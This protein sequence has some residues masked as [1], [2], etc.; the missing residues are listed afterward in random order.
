[1]PAAP[2]AIPVKPDS[3]ATNAITAKIKAHP[4][5]ARFV[6]KIGMERFS[7][8]A[9]R[10]DDRRSTRCFVRRHRRRVVASQ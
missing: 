6:D 10:G 2:A 1:M 4:S 8:E 5:M 7:A 3:P 9:A